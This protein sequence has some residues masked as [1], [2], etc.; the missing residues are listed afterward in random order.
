MSTRTKLNMTCMMTSR[1]S[2]ASDV[3]GSGFVDS[4]EEQPASR[5]EITKIGQQPL[6]FTCEHV[7]KIRDVS[8]SGVTHQI[9]KRLRISQS[10][11]KMNVEVEYVSP[12][13]VRKEDQPVS[14]TVIS[15]SDVLNRRDAKQRDIT[16]NR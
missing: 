11:L 1:W 15:L 2:G 8:S 6:S 7:R 4:L 14:I 3:K 12:D 16:S 9:L 10:D 13:I 5:G